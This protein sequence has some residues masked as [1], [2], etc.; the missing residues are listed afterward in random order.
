M[1][2]VRTT[3]YID[4]DL[5]KMAMQRKVC[6]SEETEKALR[7]KLFL[8]ISPD[9]LDFALKKLKLE[10]QEFIARRDKILLELNKE[11]DKFMEFLNIIEKVTDAIPEKD[12]RNQYRNITQSMK[13]ELM[14]GG[15]NDQIKKSS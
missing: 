15:L 13:S 3:I 10:V 5:R 7:N 14:G 11:R 9:E 6:I 8:T 4:A 1:R 2:K 12:K